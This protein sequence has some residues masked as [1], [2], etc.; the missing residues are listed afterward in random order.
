MSKLKNSNLHTDPATR[1]TESNKHD[2]SL[3]AQTEVNWNCVPTTLQVVEPLDVLSD[4]ARA[5][6]LFTMNNTANTQEM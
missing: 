6:N 3:A 5:D 4:R 2:H 1:W